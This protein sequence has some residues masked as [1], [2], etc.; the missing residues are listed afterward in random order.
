[1]T[2]EPTPA[3]AHREP[4]GVRWRIVAL[5]FFAVL[6]DGFDAA[7]LSI[8]VPTLSRQWELAPANFTGPL[9][10]TNIGVVIGYLSCGWLGARFGRRTMLIT[11]VA[12]FALM[13]GATAVA[14]PAESIAAL[15]VLR[16]GTGLGWA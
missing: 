8:A 5:A 16:F 2:A 1:M 7:T 15:S 6:L 11:G 10:L 3:T 4:V 13:T 12:V 9:V 14:L